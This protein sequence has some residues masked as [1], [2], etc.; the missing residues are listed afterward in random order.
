METVEPF[1]SHGLPDPAHWIVIVVEDDAGAIAAHTT[2]VETVHWDF[3]VEPTH[4]GNAGVFRAL[5]DSGLAELQARGVA[6]VHTTI[7]DDLPE[8]QQMAERFGFVSAPGRLYIRPIP[9]AEV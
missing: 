7:S 5:L 9:P 8:V 3:H 1:K 2:L 6:G 4:R